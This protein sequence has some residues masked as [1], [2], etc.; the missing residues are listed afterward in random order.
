[1]MN[2]YA[3]EFRNFIEAQKA[4]VV[5]LD[6]ESEHILTSLPSQ[7]ATLGCPMYEDLLNKEPLDIVNLEYHDSLSYIDNLQAPVKVITPITSVFRM[8]YPKENYKM[9]LIREGI[10][11]ELTEIPVEHPYTT[12]QESIGNM[13]EM[14]VDGRFEALWNQIYNTYDTPHTIVFS[15]T[16]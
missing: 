9:F 7:L 2:T 8:K 5:Y 16:P 4:I 3:P 14:L 10:L 13:E 11:L 6:R 1:M 15:K 12:V